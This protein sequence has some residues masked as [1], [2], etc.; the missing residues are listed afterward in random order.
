MTDIGLIGIIAFLSAIISGMLGLGGAVLLIPAYL[1]VPPFFGFSSLDVKSISGMTTVQVLASSL[2]GMLTHR[3]RG[4]VNRNLV[5]TMGIP[6]ALASFAGAMLSGVIEPN[7]ILG[8]FAL[9]ALTGA[10]LMLVKKESDQTGP[11][12]FNRAGAIAAA[13]GIGFFGGIAG[14]P[15]AFILSPVMMTVLRIPTRIT[16]GSTLGI[17]VLSAASGTIGKIATGLVPPMPTAVAVLS[18]LPGVYLGSLLS[19]R[20]PTRTLRWALAMFIGAVGLHISFKV[21]F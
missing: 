1:Y 16:I 4:S 7:I 10:L 6:V 11:L 20:I 8:T 13:A 19:H 18:S 15:G 5:L 12:E 3:A 2:L 14:A 17:V 21:L 9:M